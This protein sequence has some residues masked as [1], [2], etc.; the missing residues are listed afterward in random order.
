MAAFQTLLF[1]TTSQDRFVVGIPIA[2]RTRLEAES[3]IGLFA[4]TLAFPADLSGDPTIRELLHRVGTTAK[5]AYRHQDM[6]FEKLVEELK[7]ERDPSRMPL[8]QIMFAFQN[9]PNAGASPE[10]PHGAA[11]HPVDPLMTRPQFELAAGLAARPFKVD[12]GTAKFDLTL[13]LWEIGQ[14]FGGTWQYNADLFEAATI[15]R[16]AGHFQTLLEAIAENPDRRLSDFSFLL[17]AER[18][19]CEVERNRRLAPLLD[20]CF[21]H[22]FEEQAERTP[23]A[24]ALECGEERFTYREL[25]GRANQLARRL[26]RLGMRPEVLVGISLGRSADMV[27]GLLGALKAGGAYVP[28]DVEYPA[29]R[30]A[31]M[32]KDAGVQIL[33]TEERLLSRLKPEPGISLVCLDTD[34]EAIA[35]EPRQNT[36]SG[37]KPKNL[38]YLIYT[39]GSTGK[40][41][42]VMVTHAN[43]CH[44]VQA[45]REA[46]GVT[47]DDR[48]LHTASFAFSSSIRQLAVPLSCGAAVVVA[49]TDQIQDPSS[50]LDLVRERRA[51]IMDI[52]PSHWR[53][54][55]E[56]L[57]ALEP[58]ARAALLENDLRLIL[59]ASDRLSADLPRE[60][61]FGVCHPARMINMYGQTET[62]GIVTVYPIT[63][64]ESAIP[65]GRPIANTQVYVLDASM[66]PVPIGTSGEMYVGGAGVGSGYLNLKDLTTER[67]VP[68]PFSE[69]AGALLY[70]TGDLVRYRPDGNIEFIG[71][72]DHQIKI[73]GFRVDPAEIEAALR[74]HPD[75]RES[76]V[77]NDA[78]PIDGNN[79]LVAFVVPRGPFQPERLKREVLDFL[80]R[81]LPEYMVPSAVI[82]LDALPLTANRKLDRQAL[83]TRFVADSERRPTNGNQPALL[84]DRRTHAEEILIAIWQEVLLLDSV[85]VK[86]NFFDLGGDSLRSVQMIRRA[87]QAGLPV[88]L[89]QFFQHQT[90]AELAQA[91]RP[92]GKSCACGPTSPK[93]RTNG[94][95]SVVLVTVE[96]L[97]AYGREALQSVGVSLEGAAIVTDVQLEASLRG[98]PTH[99]MDSI[100]R[101]ARRIAAGRMN[102]VPNIRIEHETAISAQ[103][104]GD[105]GPGQWVAVVAIETAIRKAKEKGIAVVGVRRSNHLGAA[106]HYVW[107][108]AQQQLIGLCTTNGPAT[109]APIGD[110]TPMFGNN[111]LGVGI[112]SGRYHPILLDIAM[113]VAPRG[114]IGLQ[115]A[116]GKP[117]PPGW[118][119]DRF[120]RPSTDP[121]DLVAGLAA[122]I[123][124]HKGY[125]L[126]LIFEVLAGALTGAGFCRDHDR[127]LMH[128]SS[129][130][131]DLGHFLMVIDPALFG[132]PA[133]FMARVDSLIE[134]T[135]SAER[136][137]NVEEILI[138][139]E[140]EL[141]AR[142]RNIRE[143]VPLQPLAYR[144][145]RKYGEDARLESDLVVVR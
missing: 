102:P 64:T 28:L 42:G 66:R 133:E 79:R 84:D 108:A 144:A 67:F 98:Q 22:I 19:Q 117:L 9:L 51:S 24:V 112:P 70:R 41:K 74:E 45:M 23:D 141:R 95:Q 114:K 65:I 20:R 136:A 61:T 94:A 12:S 134:Q 77:V 53:S 82:E 113:S 47:S 143:G 56:E 63:G 140:A 145:L 25:N 83:S 33:V 81:K 69:T 96:S 121:A 76:A 78:T 99:N 57:Q 110:L 89:K 127:E 40:P 116:E 103:M 122:P 50:L 11:A 59:S 105:N 27:V 13:Y 120:G 73:R 39:S 87:N 58:A 111:P 26:Q 118:I 30:L 32:L 1:R 91:A 123:G 138:P 72:A 135:K 62:T 55:I 129:Q 8:V 131:R 101:Y 132:P 86:D 126:A 80:K 6:S 4:N 18:R 106:G 119:L 137:E 68:D 44:Y 71:R 90:V 29:E 10:N 124:G 43:L 7:L 88:T 3:L 46:I 17:E 75:L 5:G 14:E 15:E 97:R 49:Q 130:P 139:G 125:G 37:A 38:A 52:V 100:P 85:G 48:Y 60:W 128:N 2:N 92:G 107:L 21:H 115:L 109:L 16:I 104:D 54:C 142:E 31:F 34:K 35:R 36:E 93:P